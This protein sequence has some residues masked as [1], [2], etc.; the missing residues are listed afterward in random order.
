MLF[1]SDQAVDKS[2]IRST[3]LPSDGGSELT[4][5]PTGDYELL[6]AVLGHD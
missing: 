4:D 5:V 3:Q 6:R 1:T 2:E